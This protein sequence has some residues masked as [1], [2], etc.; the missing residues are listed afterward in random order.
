MEIDKGLELWRL[1]EKLTIVQA[2][3]LI[4][5]LNPARC[6]VADLRKLENSI[7]YEDDDWLSSKNAANFRAAYY[8]IVQAGRNNRLKI[9]WEVGFPEDIDEPSSHVLVEDLK[10]W[11]SSRGQ[12]PAF[13]FPEGGAGEV[14]DQKYAF[15]NP[16]HPRYAP[17][18][19]AAVAAWEV[20]SEAAPG[21]S[22]KATLAQWLQENGKKYVKKN[23]E[24]TKELIQQ[25]SSVANWEPTGGAPPKTPAN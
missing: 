1:L 4:V 17:K 16:N 9:E 3:F 21:K 19:A 13:F 18:L 12:R 23:G 24:V 20:V 7:I 22:V 25:A 11:L 6:R 15:Q 8:A 10:E 2:A 5:G 14:K